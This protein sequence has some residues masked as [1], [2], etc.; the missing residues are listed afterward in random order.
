MPTAIRQIREEVAVFSAKAATGWSP[1]VDTSQLRHVTFY[2]STQDSANLTLKIA[3]SDQDDVAFGTAQ[4]PTNRWDYVKVKDLEDD[5]GIDGDTGIVVTG[6][7]AFYRL[8]INSNY[9][10]WTAFQVSARSAGSVN[11][12]IA[13][14]SN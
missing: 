6:T 13:G 14:S 7:D 3:Q 10:K 9:A 11:I 8:E 4:G 2:F 12:H 1:K 5:A